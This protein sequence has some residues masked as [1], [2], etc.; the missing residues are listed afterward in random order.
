MVRIKRPLI[1]ILAGFVVL[2]AVYSLTRYHLPLW[3]EAVYLGMGKFLYSGGGS[4]LWEQ[5]RPIGLPILTGL[6]WI[7]GISQM[8]W[9][10]ALMLIFASGCIILTYLIAKQVCGHQEAAITAVLVASTPVFFLETGSFL[11]EI[12]STFFVLLAVYLFLKEKPFCSGLAAG[13][14][15]LFKFPQGLIFIVLALSLISSG[16][17]DRKQKFV[18]PF[19]MMLC[20]LSIGVLIQLVFNSFIYQGTIFERTVWPFLQASM[21]QGN[22]YQSVFFT[23]GSTEVAYLYNLFYIIVKMAI[24]QPALLFSLAAV[25]PVFRSADKKKRAVLL[26]AVIYLLYYTLILNKQERFIIMML[27]FFALLA[28]SVLVKLKR[29]SIPV[30]TISILI[31]SVSC[32]DTFT[33]TSA[34]EPEIVNFYRYFDVNSIAGQ[35][36]TADPVFAAYSDKLFIPIYDTFSDPSIDTDAVVYTDAS[37]PCS[38]EP[39]IDRRERLHEMARQGRSLVLNESYYGKE[40]LIYIR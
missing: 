1:Y 11:T 14:A 21:H 6:P 31:G 23:M 8:S 7:I 4:G 25:G 29:W 5:I 40:Y 34:T 10:T 35:I 18:T 30:I 3:D 39:C 27:P 28:S 9:M 17:I 38:D 26:G 13:A 37:Y 36:S 32:Y 2:R 33:S 24:G 22:I 16:L 20:G 19:L 12:P 15:F